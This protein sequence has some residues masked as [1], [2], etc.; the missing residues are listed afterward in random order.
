MGS[1]YF[2][3]QQG[4]ALLLLLM[5]TYIRAEQKASQTDKQLVEL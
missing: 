3:A 2:K 4:R 1:V 5:L